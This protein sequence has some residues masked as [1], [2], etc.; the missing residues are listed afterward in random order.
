[1]GTCSSTNLSRC[2]CTTETCGAGLLDAE[3]AL[4]F[5]QSPTGYT[6][7]VRTA[8]SLSSAAI[9]A[10]GVKQGTKV[11]VAD[12]VPPVTTPSAP[13]TT[14]DTSSNGGG[15]GG[16]MSAYWLAALVAAALLL[17]R[18]KRPAAV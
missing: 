11:V 12:P 16:A 2:S 5:A 15:G 14:P 4:R 10:C 8:V 3:E 6:A 13:A 7:P 1:L 9:D 18:D 17:R